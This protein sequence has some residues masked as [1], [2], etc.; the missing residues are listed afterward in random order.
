MSWVKRKVTPTP[1]K[2]VKTGWFGLVNR[3]IASLYTNNWK[4]FNLGLFNSKYLKL[5]WFQN[6]NTL[7]PGLKWKRHNF[8]IENALFSRMLRMHV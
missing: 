8:K 6:E 7:I 4:H 2:E 3:K 5:D 1:G